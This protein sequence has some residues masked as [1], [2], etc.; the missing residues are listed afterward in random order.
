MKAWNRIERS[1]R[2]KRGVRPHLGVDVSEGRL[3]DVEPLQ[4]GQVPA[5]EDPGLQAGDGGV[6]HVEDLG[7]RGHHVGNCCVK[8]SC[9]VH[10]DLAGSPETLAV[11]RTAASATGHNHRNEER[12][13]WD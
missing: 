13:D 4:V 3:A 2:V 10:R 11:V 9:T 6:G 7:V 12:K 8:T 5:E 1:E